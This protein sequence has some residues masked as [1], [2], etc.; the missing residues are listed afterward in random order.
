M[1]GQQ[2]TL[3]PPA[4][5]SQGIR[6][7]SAEAAMQSNPMAGTLNVSSKA[8]TRTD[9]PASNS[10]NMGNSGGV[11]SISQDPKKRGSKNTTPSSV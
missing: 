2:E 9:A 4:Y 5:N 3:K 6:A 8:F 11:H 1:G 7:D 10:S